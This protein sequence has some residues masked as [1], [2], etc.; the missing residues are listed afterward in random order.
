MAINF[1]NG[2][3]LLCFFFACVW[4]KGKGDACNKVFALVAHLRINKPEAL[5]KQKQ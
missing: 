5:G 1:S 3:Y 2:R 4:K